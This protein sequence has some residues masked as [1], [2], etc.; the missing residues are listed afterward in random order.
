MSIGLCVRSRS[1]VE[2]ERQMQTKLNDDDS[3]RTELQLPCPIE[4]CPF[5]D[6]VQSVAAHV[7]SGHADGWAA[8]TYEPYELHQTA[9]MLRTGTAYRIGKVRAWLE[10]NGVTTDAVAVYEHAAYGSI[11][12]RQ[13]G[14]IDDYAAFMALMRDTDAVHYNGDVNWLDDELVRELPEVDAFERWVRIQNG[15][16][17]AAQCSASGCGVTE[18]VRPV[19]NADGYTRRLCPSH[20]K[21]FL[22][23]SS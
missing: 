8:A 2:H 4:G 10:R 6:S 23:V 17:N 3:A 7:G 12:I 11:Q 21:R 20:A 1:A 14:Y 5:S 13:V 19:S 15:G 9:S 22:G 16:N 18:G